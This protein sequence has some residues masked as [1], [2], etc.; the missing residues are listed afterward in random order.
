[1]YSCSPDTV[2]EGLPIRIR[3]IAPSSRMVISVGAPVGDSTE[4]SESS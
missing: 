3:F 4:T 1:M 2:C